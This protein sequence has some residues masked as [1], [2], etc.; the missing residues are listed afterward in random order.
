MVIVVVRILLLRIFPLLTPSDWV[1]LSTSPSS[2]MKSSTSLIKRVP[3]L[4][5]LGLIRLLL[6]YLEIY[7]LTWFQRFFTFLFR[8]SFILSP[9]TLRFHFHLTFLEK[10][11][12]FLFIYLFIFIFIFAG[13]FRKDFDYQECETL[14]FV[15]FSCL[16]CY[17]NLLFCTGYWLESRKKV[18]NADH[19]SYLYHDSWGG[20]AINCMAV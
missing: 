5:R 20:W 12:N 14:L 18:A 9:F 16:A 3:W 6:C 10:I 2:T 1:L 19:S 13:M 17:N 8:Q 15:K 4:N 7:R 11:R